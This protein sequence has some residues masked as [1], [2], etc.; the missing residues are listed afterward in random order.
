MVI[1]VITNETKYKRVRWQDVNNS[2]LTLMSTRKIDLDSFHRLCTARATE[3]Y[4]EPA[5][6]LI[7]AVGNPTAPISKRL[8]IQCGLVFHNAC[9]WTCIRKMC[10][11]C[12][13][14]IFCVVVIINNEVELTIVIF[15]ETIKLILVTD[16]TD[17][18]CGWSLNENCEQHGMP[19]F[20]LSVDT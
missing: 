16:D 17:I 11:S 9:W 2:C 3:T 5:H 18:P 10:A 15:L 1:S 13:E 12:C 20:G 6:W 14:N 19:R 7:S 8:R 4:C